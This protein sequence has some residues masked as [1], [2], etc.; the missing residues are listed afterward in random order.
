MLQYLQN[1][2]WAMFTLKI[3]VLYFNWIP[4]FVLF[5]W[6]KVNKIFFFRPT[7][8]FWAN[9]VD[10]TSQKSNVSFMITRISGGYYASVV[11]TQEW[12][13]FASSSSWSYLVPGNPVSSENTVLRLLWKLSSGTFLLCFDFLFFVFSLLYAVQG[14]IGLALS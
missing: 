12:N 4:M 2:F 9:L 6:L 8:W 3:S 13:C 7:S 1:L 11:E 14:A 10:K 5:L